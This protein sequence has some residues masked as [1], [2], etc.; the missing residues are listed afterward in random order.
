MAALRVARRARDETQGARDP[1]FCNLDGRDHV[2][3]SQQEFAILRA[4]LLFDPDRKLLVSKAFYEALF[5]DAPDLQEMFS[6]DVFDQSRKFSATLVV[7][8]NALSDWEV[9]HPVLE[10]LARRQLSYGVTVGHYDV[11]GDALCTCLRQQGA[12][13]QERQVWAK[14]YRILATHMIAAAYPDATRGP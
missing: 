13:K 14:V 11:V 3:L 4:S 12:S 6:S 7:A 10:A 8:V 9:L 5:A 2:M 1:S